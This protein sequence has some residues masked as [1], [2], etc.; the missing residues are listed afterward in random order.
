MSIQIAHAETDFTTTCPSV[1]ELIKAEGSLQFE[2]ILGYDPHSNSMLGSLDQII[3]L[4]EKEE[5]MFTISGFPVAN[6]DNIDD[7][8]HAAMN[9]L[10]LDSTVPA[11]FNIASNRKDKG[12]HLEE[13]GPFKFCYYTVPNNPQIK[14][15]TVY[16]YPK[17][18]R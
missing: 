5:F 7:S 10:Q 6:G 17:V 4:S 3:A 14:A 15:I 2:N 16:Y 18:A 1:D 12:D 13:D 8:A 11:T 9:S